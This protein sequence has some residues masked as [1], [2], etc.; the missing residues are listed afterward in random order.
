MKYAGLL[1][2]T[3]LSFTGFA[4]QS[5]FIVL[6]SK[7]N[8]TL[9]TYYA[10]SFIK[11]KTH[12]DF[13]INGWI[14]HI[15]QDT[16]YI[17]QTIV[18]QYYSRLGVPHLDTLVYKLSFP[19]TDIREFYYKKNNKKF[20]EV[21]IPGI[22]IRAGYFY[23]LLETVN[24][25]YRGEKF[26]EYGHLE[27]IAGGVAVG[28]AGLLWNAVKNSKNKVGGKYRVIYMKSSELPATENPV[29]EN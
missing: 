13:L 18:E 4:Q 1:L 23:A 21:T 24:T 15:S 11:A 12:N 10:G 6:K 26:S 20:R 16:L 22:M 9:K 29:T 28:S 5:D 14:D 25:L 7:N 8:K 19:Y 3:L 2:L 27:S 17:T